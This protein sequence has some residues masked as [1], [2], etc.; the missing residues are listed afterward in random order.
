M[1]VTTSFL[2]FNGG[3]LCAEK[4]VVPDGTQEKLDGS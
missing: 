1:W 4:S 3:E 2:V